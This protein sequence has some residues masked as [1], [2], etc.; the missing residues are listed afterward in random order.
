LAYKCWY[1]KIKINIRNIIDYQ[2]RKEIG[3]K[4]GSGRIEKKIDIVVSK[5]QKRKAMAW[6]ARGARNLALLITYHKDC[7]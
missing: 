7:A 6:S 3:K 5:R 1:L 4:I 2:Y